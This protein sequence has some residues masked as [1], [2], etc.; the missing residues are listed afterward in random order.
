MLADLSQEEIRK[1]L[2]RG[3]LKKLTPNTIAD[4]TSLSEELKRIRERGFALDNEETFPGIRCVGAPVRDA[5]GKVIAA[6]SVTVP[7]QR[8]NDK[9]IREL[10]RLVTGTARLISERVAAGRMEA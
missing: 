9:R 2:G 4:L 5:A 1:L 7:A 8:M 3:K 10:W 6:V